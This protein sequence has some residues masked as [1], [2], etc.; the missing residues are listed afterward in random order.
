MSP[1]PSSS[2]PYPL[3]EPYYSHFRYPPDDFI[4]P[5]PNYATSPLH[6]ATGREGG[7]M[8][9]AVPP[10]LIKM[11]VAHN[12][13][14]HPSNVNPEEGDCTCSNYPVMAAFP[15]SSP[16]PAASECLPISPDLTTRKPPGTESTNVFF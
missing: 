5:P 1:A 2:S 8:Y 6:M 13:S 9:D 16:L 11:E 12:M 7:Y 3:R 10:T 4:P 15:P 14:Q